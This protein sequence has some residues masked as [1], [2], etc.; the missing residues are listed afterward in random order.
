DE[1][2]FC[3]WQKIKVQ[4]PIGEMENAYTIPRTVEVMLRDD[5]VEL[6]K[7]GDSLI[8]TGYLVAALTE[9]NVLGQSVTSKKGLSKV[10]ERE[11]ERGKASK[12]QTVNHEFL[13]RALSISKSQ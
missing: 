5:L 12:G 7:P 8:I 4:E 3:D 11:A 13:F 2:V 1:S 6:A 9:K 10:P